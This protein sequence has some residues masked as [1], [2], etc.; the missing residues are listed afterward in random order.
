MSNNARLFY[1]PEI[2]SV[3]ELPEDE[4]QHCTRVLRLKKGDPITITDGKGFFYL[5]SIKNVQSKHCLVNIMKRWPQKMLRN[6]TVHLAVA[7]TKNMERMEWFIEKATEIG[8]DTI[9]FLCCHHSERKEIKLQRLNKTAINAMK[10]SQKASFPQINEMADIHEFI[11]WNNNG[12]KMIAHCAND[13][14]QLIKN[15]Y[16]QGSDA[17]ILIGPEGDFSPEEINAAISA[18]FAPVSL[19]DSRLRTETAALIACHTI[20]LLNQ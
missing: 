4:S 1:A 10:Q 13:C 11:S 9:T 3:P 20:H 16:T 19:G 7:P 2:D 6:Y 5:A 15:I 8:I 17:L 12:I 14:K 18:G